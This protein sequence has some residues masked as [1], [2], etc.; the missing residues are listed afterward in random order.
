MLRFR[1]RYA[2]VGRKRSIFGVRCCP[3]FQASPEGLGTQ[4]RW[5]KGDDCTR[6]PPSG[7]RSCRCQGGD[8]G[9]R[10]GL[11]TWPRLALPPCTVRGAA[12]RR[13]AAR[14]PRA[15]GFEVEAGYRSWLVDLVSVSAISQMPAPCKSGAVGALGETRMG[16]MRPLSPRSWTREQL[17]VRLAVKTSHEAVQ[18]VCGASPGRGVGQGR[19]GQGRG[20]RPGS[21]GAVW[22]SAP[23]PW[24]PLAPSRVSQGGPSRPHWLRFVPCGRPSGQLCRPPGQLML[25][26]EPTL[27]GEQGR[28]SLPA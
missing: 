20:G 4:C 5:I 16:K 17:A 23:C 9:K 13:V 28:F 19:G 18:A 6:Q 14:V 24:L 26:S 21:G 12:P 10:P 7:S 2:G 11:S 1:E 15:H 27:Q 25:P 8:S 3:W 22:V